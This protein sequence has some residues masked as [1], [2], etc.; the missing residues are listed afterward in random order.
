MP[1][2][3]GPS[4]LGR[5]FALC[6]LPYLSYRAAQVLFEPIAM[7]EVSDRLTGICQSG[8]TPSGQGPQGYTILKTTVCLLSNFMR[9]ALDRHRA[10]FMS[11]LFAALG[12]AIILPAIEMRRSGYRSSVTLASMLLLGVLYQS[13]SGAIVLPLWWSFYLAFHGRQSVPLHAHFAEATFLGYLLGYLMVSVA[14]VVYQTS[15][16]AGLWQLFP[17]YVVLIQALYLWYQRNSTEDIPDCPYEVLQLIHVTNFCWSAITHAYTLFQAFSS[18]AP[19]QAL[20]HSFYPHFSPNSAA[21]LPM[22]TQRF[23]KWDVLFIVGATLFA[24]V[25][26]LRGARPKLLAVCWF[27]VGSLFFGVGAGLSGI[28]MWREKVL[29]EHRRTSVAK[30][31]EE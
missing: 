19:L 18:P 17:A 4:K 1:S 24:G 14:M 31:R 8:S 7:S 10:P 27:A 16:M 9:E 15:A 11:E 22:L 30:L 26:L 3:A 25:S 13:C 5:T 20:K 23:L 29:E 2:Y 21:P 28:W 12:P 6:V